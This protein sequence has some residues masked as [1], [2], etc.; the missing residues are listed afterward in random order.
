MHYVAKI[1]KAS[2]NGCLFVILKWDKGKV[3][4]LISNY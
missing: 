4:F 2:E 1:K 3:K